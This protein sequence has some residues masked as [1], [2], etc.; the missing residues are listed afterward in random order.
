MRYDSKRRNIKTQIT[1]F[2]VLS[3]NLTANITRYLANRC[4]HDFFSNPS[5]NT[6]FD[7]FCIYLFMISFHN[8]SKRTLRN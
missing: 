2:A 6:K 8:Q 4:K 7:I 3:F 1:D 5:L